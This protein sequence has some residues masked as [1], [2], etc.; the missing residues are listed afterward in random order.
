MDASST[1]PNEIHPLTGLRGVAALIVFLH[2]ARYELDTLFPE[3]SF[4]FFARGYLGVDIFF[5]LSGF[6]IAYNYG[7]RIR[8]ISD[9]TSYV[10]RRIARIYPMH[11]ATLLAV[12]AMVYTAQAAGW[13]IHDPDRYALDHYLLLHLTMTHAWGL[14]EELRYN[15][16]SWSISAEFFVYLML[17][18][19]WV[20]AARIR[21][22]AA[23][24]GAA[25]ACT[26][27]TVLVLQALGHENLNVPTRG[28][29]IRATGEFLAGCLVFQAWALGGRSSR[30]LGSTGGS[31]A[32]VAV[33]LVF[34]SPYADPLMSPAAVVLVYFLAR[35]RD[36]FSAVLA[37][38][39]MLWLG[40]ISYSL[41]LTHLPLLSVL[42]RV[43]PEEP[44]EGTTARI[45]CALG[46]GVV[47]IGVAA[48]AYYTIEQPGRR[49]IRV[50]GSPRT[51]AVAG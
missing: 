47:A 8:S 44:P 49:W 3:L 40:R 38:P 16:P 25:L 18:V 15:L 39:A 7:G 23:A 5:V 14:G 32:L 6:V 19:L 10:G 45:G 20:Q 26:A 27:L 42:G 28:A 43:L 21:G 12:L 34:V 17:P 24:L 35:G 13:R 31:L 36:P 46:L 51:G 22:V 29:L 2:H 33:A 48:A 11:V 50:R 9:Y 30:A 41:Y 37:A 1:K 4:E